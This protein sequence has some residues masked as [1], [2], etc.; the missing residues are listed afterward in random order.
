MRNILKHS[1]ALNRVLS[2]MLVVLMV[3]S[4]GVAQTFAA[5]ITQG[6][7]T[8]DNDSTPKTA[9]IKDINFTYYSPKTVF[10]FG[11]TGGFNYVNSTGDNGS[12][13]S[14]IVVTNGKGYCAY[15]AEKDGTL[16]VLVKNASAKQGFISRKNADG[17]DEAIG[18]FYPGGAEVSEDSFKVTQGTNY[19]T[20]DIEVEAGYTYYIC[21][22]GSKMQCWG[23]S[24]VP[25]TNI[26]GSIDNSVG[27]TDYGIKFTDSVND[28]VKEAKVD[29]ANNTYSIS[30]KP[31]ISYAAS[32]TGSAAANYA[33]SNA[34]RLVTP[35]GDSMTADLAI[36]KSL[37]YKIS[38][39]IKGFASDYDLSDLALKFVPSDVNSFAT[40]KADIDKASLTYTAQL[41]AN[42]DYT[43][44]QECA[45][46]YEL[47]KEVKV[48]Q[49]ESTDVQA[50]A[51]FKLVATYDVSGNFI[52]LGDTRGKYETA[53]A[54]VTAIKFTNVDDKYEYNLTVAD[55]GFS[56]KL[57]NGSY[58][59]SIT[60]EDY[61]TST[62]IV[63]DGKPASKDILLKP[64]KQEAVA[65]KAEIEV[66]AD[67]EYKTVQAAVNAVA[68]M[69]REASQ[70]V[71]IKIDP[72]K[73]RE[74]VY[75]TAPNIT[76]ESNGGNR[77]N[78]I[79]TWYYGIG[80]KYYSCVNSLY[81]PYAD[82]DKFE[83]G[84]AVSYWGSAVVVNANATGF[85][86]KNIGFENSFNKYMTEEELAD[87]VE[88]NGLTS[89]NVERKENTNVDTKTAT[90]RAAALVNY[91]DKTEFLNCSFVGSQDT[92]YTC[93][94]T[95]M[96]YYKNCYIEGQTDF[97][98]GNGDVLF[99]G[100]EINWCGYD[101]A[102]A[103]GYLTAQSSDPSRTAGYVFRNCIVTGN[104]E[105][106]VAP[107]Y[108][109]RMW[110]KGATVN[111]INTQVENPDYLAGA[112]WSSM[113]GVNPTDSTVN[114]KEYNTTYNGVK[115]DTAS[116]VAGNVDSLNVD[117][118]S[119][120]TVFTANG[121]TP[122]YYTK[123]T[124]TPAIVEGPSF[125]SNG[126]LNTLNPGETV[127]ANFALNDECKG[128]S[129]S[130]IS[131]YAVDTDFDNTS[132]ETIL[133]KSTLLYTTADYVSTSFQLPMACE[134]K[135]IMAVVTPIVIGGAA[136]G[137]AK[138][139]IDTEKPISGNWSNP[140]NPGEIA[141]GSG[142]NI[143][144]A[145]DS[146]V[147]DY[148]EKGIYNGGKILSSG[149]WGEFL[150]YFF[151]E[152]R[153]Q[154]NNY[155]Q[156]GRSSRS[157]INEGKLDTIKS[158]IKKGDYLLVQFG[159][160][161]CA[162]GASYYAERFAPL[163]AKANG[164]DVVDGVYP[165]V[166][167]TEDLKTTTPDAYKSSYGDKYYSW[168]CGATY[169]GYLQEYINVA[170]EAGATPVIVSPVSRM[171]YTSDGKIKTHHDANMTDYEPTKSFLTQNDAYV[172]ACKQL[173]EEN[174]AKGNNVLY[175][176]AFGLTK[177]AFEDAWADCSSNANGVAMMDNGDSTHC[178]K[179][180][181]VLEAA[182]IARWIKDADLSASEYVQAPDTIYGENPDG[183]YIVT[184]KDKKVTAKDNKYNV[185]SFVT[186]YT[187]NIFD[188]LE[189]KTPVSIVYGDANGDGK[190]TLEDA[191]LIY[192]K[193]LSDDF[194]LSVKNKAVDVDK[195]G[196]ITA[197]DAVIV[198]KK[199]Q[200]SS[201]VMPVE[202]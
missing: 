62:H 188:E 121:W 148:S 129:A 140:D 45:Y 118:Y 120:E 57:R 24:F 167:P 138:Y 25:Y 137:E 46:D 58:I 54:N 69:T 65:Y 13:S 12:A 66:G 73:Y 14:G 166:L 152:E 11:A 5:E 170:L 147:K 83:K 107:G 165:T 124:G 156:G 29:L 28:K 113:A 119:V 111:F 161:D 96:A 98:Y 44:K 176:D 33:I 92:L 3:L 84:N 134:G 178:N 125:T 87:G 50:D 27:A 135:Y 37:T 93:N 177:Q 169:K 180:G 72:G 141:P 88:V 41:T 47:S 10:A 53:D 16:T 154:V 90:E 99:D 32:L 197:T 51:E 9:T 81:D 95:F 131:W 186:N 23:A 94:K 42:V 153:V 39:S 63:V 155:A 85:N 71:T 60:C 89:I 183:K 108:F 196:K 80:Y 122:K 104:K 127:K 61:S 74:Q 168:D 182:L 64:T 6:E 100:C 102:E 105:R 75:V 70:G 91:A 199:A 133:Q 55:K 76:L 128:A 164:A 136:E 146:T 189:N 184:V 190:V 101:G 158:K 162:N 181:G 194:E 34:T 192:K 2:L 200:D 173:Y 31:N 139:I 191:E 115:V 117:D 112:G 151:D 202:K 35:T 77:D 174:I 160:N 132:L 15:P 82:Y 143:F 187:Q 52:K 48:N 8:I 18:S 171:Y 20:V 1:K 68:N 40:V 17:A 193:A 110:G 179:S 103:A 149:S 144:L 4:C 79:I 145:G 78:T 150:Q 38:G 195:D 172:T 142:I 26:T 22:S 106:T 185:N 97:I 116:R 43:L 21:L 49:A 123:A 157:F 56:G 36:E 175:L 7:W 198:T 126:D 59:A 30:L 19:A 201:Y 86:A 114:L 109:G 130:R 159:H 67:K 163:Y